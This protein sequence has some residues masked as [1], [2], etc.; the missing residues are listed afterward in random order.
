[1][2]AFTEIKSKA[3]AFESK[4][5]LIPKTIA[6]VSAL[7]LMAVN[8][9]AETGSTVDISAVTDSMTSSLSDLATKVGV[10]CAGVV[11]A[12]LTI[13]AMKW[14]VGKVMAFFKAIGK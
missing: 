2:N 1:M 13:F 8:A 11:G 6:A 12:G 7:E 14:A 9:S 5:K 4:H 3:I 10:A